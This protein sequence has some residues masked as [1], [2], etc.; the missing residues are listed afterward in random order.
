[1]SNTALA[2]V[3]V[4][5]GGAAFVWAV[6]REVR[7]ARRERQ[8][9]THPYRTGPVSVPD[10]GTVRVDLGAIERPAGPPLHAAPTGEA[11]EP[12][13]GKRARARLLGVAAVPGEDEA[14]EYTTAIG[15]DWLWAYMPRAAIDAEAAALADLLE[16][17]QREGLHPFVPGGTEPTETGKEVT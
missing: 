2:V 6:A 4:S 3:G 10:D 16:R 5:L 17:Q 13:P 7:L 9:D 12:A 15:V 1:M 8:P 14:G 11:V